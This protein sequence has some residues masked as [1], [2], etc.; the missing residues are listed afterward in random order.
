MFLEYLNNI[1]DP[2]TARGIV[3]DSIDFT[4]DSRIIA[5]ST[6]IE[7]RRSER[8]VVFGILVE[9]EGFFHPRLW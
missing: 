2:E 7:G 6:C 4:I 5:L 8:F 9:R 1:T 3:D